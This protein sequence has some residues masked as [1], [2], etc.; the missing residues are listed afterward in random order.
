MADLSDILKELTGVAAQWKH[1]GIHLG[2]RIDKLNVIQ[3]Q[4]ESPTNC[5]TQMLT[6][7]LRRAYDVKRFGDPTW[8][9]LVEVVG[10]EAGGGDPSLAA[11][12]AG[13]HGKFMLATTQ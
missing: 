10:H 6:S 11:E 12:I 5:L 2:I 7:W 8:V 1:I 9:K 4:E 13:R 3:L